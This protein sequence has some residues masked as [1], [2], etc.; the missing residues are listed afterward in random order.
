VTAAAQVL[1]G[2]RITASIIQ[3]VAPLAA[4]KATTQSV[5]SSTTLVNDSNLF[6]SMAANSVY[7]VQAD[8]LF[9]G[10]SAG[11]IKYTFTVPSGASGG[12]GIIQYS[13]GGTFQAF[14]SSAWTNTNTAQ[15]SSPAQPAWLSGLLITS[16]VP[17]SLQLQWAQNAS[18]ATATTMGAYSYLTAWQI[19]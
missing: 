14:T 6:L 11:N 16:T 9:G 4:Y 15:A 17:G 13:T 7:V 1:A 10:G 8:L 2:A 3:G 12:F 18:N 5:T 19:G